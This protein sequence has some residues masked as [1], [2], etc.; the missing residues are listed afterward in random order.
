MSQGH[1]ANERLEI[2]QYL[3]AVSILANVV[4]RWCLADKGG[5]A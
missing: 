5:A 1:A 4:L 3:D 2:D